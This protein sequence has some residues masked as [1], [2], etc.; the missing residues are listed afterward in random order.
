MVVL[1]GF[2]VVVLVGFVVMVLAGFVVAVGVGLG[3]GLVGFGAGLGLVAFTVFAGAVVAVVATAGVVMGKA[4]GRVTKVGRLELW[5]V[6]G[7]LEKG[8]ADGLAGTVVVVDEVVVSAIGA[9]EA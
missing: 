9:G 8:R 7:E 2:V 5:D 1:A 3:V 4:A 6:A